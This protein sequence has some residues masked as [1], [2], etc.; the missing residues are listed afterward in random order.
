MIAILLS[1]YNSEQYL[2]SQ[3]DSILAQTKQNWLLYV[4][5]DGSNDNTINIIKQYSKLNKKIIYIED[6]IKGVGA[7]NNFMSL[8]Q[9]VNADYYMFCD[10]DDVWLPDKIEVEISEMKDIEIKNP[11]KAII[12]HSDLEVVDVN[13]N[14]KSYS[15][16]KLSKINPRLIANKSMIQVFNCVTGCTMLFNNKAKIVSFPYPN[17]APMHDWWI[18]I[19]VMRKKGLI[20][21]IDKPTILYRQHDNNVVG[22]RNV[23]GSYFQK[24]LNNLNKTLEGHIKHISFLKEINGLNAIQ[25]YFYK[26]IYTIIRFFI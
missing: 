24:K 12:V 17:S 6:N 26:I 11:D 15:F 13:L 21:H 19:S 8:L 1:T 10:H 3:I 4:Q 5:D 22:A 20:S 2:R 7:M 18:A 9:K 14:R 23:N 16:W 25:Y